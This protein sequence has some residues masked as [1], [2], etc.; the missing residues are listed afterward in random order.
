M[1]RLINTTGMTEISNNLFS[2][3]INFEY[4]KTTSRAGN[5]E[6]K[7]STL[8]DNHVAKK[9]WVDY[10]TWGCTQMY[11]KLYLYLTGRRSLT[12][13]AMFILCPVFP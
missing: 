7:I 11:F 5:K 8:A 10:G 6:S 12:P 9:N 3:Q 13:T 1:Q 2:N 4:G